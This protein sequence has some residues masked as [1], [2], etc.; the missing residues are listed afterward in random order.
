MATFPEWLNNE[1][2]EAIF[3]DNSLM[4]GYK[5][6]NAD[7]NDGYVFICD[8][9]ILYPPGFCYKMINHLK[10]LP[11]RSVASIMG[12]NLLPLPIESYAND[13]HEFF[14]AF[15][16]HSQ[17]YEV[18]LIGMCGAVYH[19]S[20][21]RV[22]DKD[23]KVTDSDVCMSAYC[24]KHNI[25]KFVVPHFGTWCKDLNHLLPSDIE[26]MW[27]HNKVDK[28]DKAITDFI[29]TNIGQIQ[30]ETGNSFA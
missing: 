26:T 5:F 28:R 24:H 25:R 22:N 11:P 4:D 6:L 15:E 9:D 17:Y 1:K 16:Y 27:T 12:K 21:C 23:M 19:S 13:V 30:S 18:N 10:H 8:D 20:Y 3:T 29:N 7:K 2:I 14:R